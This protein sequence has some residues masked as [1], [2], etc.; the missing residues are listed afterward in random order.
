MKRF[1]SLLFLFFLL[2]S[3]NAQKVS[4]KE[5]ILGAKHFIQRYSDFIGYKVRDVQDLRGSDGQ[6]LGYVAILQPRGFV[7]LT[8]DKRQNPVFGYSTEG[9]FKFSDSYALGIIRR[10]LLADR[11]YAVEKK[12]QQAENQNLWNNL[13]SQKKFSPKDYDYQYGYWLTDVWGGVNC[14]DNNGQIVYVLNYYTPH[15]YSPGCVAV[16]LS[17]VLHYY[18]W[19]PRGTGTHTDYDNE[20]SSTGSYYAKFVATEYDWANM[21]DEYYYKP[22]TDIQRRAAGLLAYHCAIATD[23]DFEYNGST[24]NINRVPN[25]LMS[26]FRMVGHYEDRS[27]SYFVSR[28][29]SNLRNAHPVILSAVADNGDEHAFVCDGY[30]YNVGEEKYYHLNMGWWNAY[31]LNGWYRIF[32]SNFNVGGYTTITAG[33]FDIVPRAYMDKPIYTTDPHKIVL[34]WRMPK[35]VNVTAYKLEESYNNGDWQVISSSITD[36]FYVREV[37]SDGLYKYRVKAQIDGIWYA[38]TYSNYINVPVGKAVYLYFDGDDSFFAYDN[39]FNDLDVDS[40]WTFEAWVEVDDYQDNDWSVIMDRRKV[41]SLYL[42][43]DYDADFAVRFAVRDASDNI[44]A[45]LRS[46]SSDVN[47]S[48]GQWFHVAVSYDGTTA[49]LFINGKQVDES[50]SSAFV[51][52]HSTNALNFAARY[53]GGYSRYL[54]GRLDEIRI[55]DVARYTE[56]F[57]PDRF[58]EFVS[59]A[60]TRLLLHLDNFTGESLFDDSHHIL[61]ISLRS[62]PND[63]SWASSQC[64]IVL[65]SPKNT[66]SCGEQVQMGISAYN[67]SQY[68]W[69]KKDVGDYYDLVNNAIYSGVDSDTLSIDASYLNG[70][71]YFRCIVRNSWMF[72]CSQPAYLKAFGNCTVWDGASW[73]NGLPD[74]NKTAVIAHNY[75][76]DGDIT[77]DN[78]IVRTGD[79]LVVSPGDSFTADFMQNNGTTILQ[80][81]NDNLYSGALLVNDVLNYGDFIVRKFIPASIT[82]GNLYLINSP[83]DSL[84]PYDSLLSSDIT[85]FKNTGSPEQWQM[86]DTPATI[87]NQT[88]YLVQAQSPQIIDFKGNINDGEFLFQL[89]QGWNLLYNPYPCVIDWNSTIGW[90]KYDVQNAIYTIYPTNAG[91]N[92]SVFNGQVS[93]HQQDRYINAMQGFFVYANSDNA[94]LSLNS[95]AKIKT[96]DIQNNTD[97]PTNYL[98]FEFENS[99]GIKDEAIA[100]FTLSGE[101]A[102]KIL[103]LTDEKTYTY[104]VQVGSLLSIAAINQLTPDTVLN[105]GFKTSASGE[106][107]FRVKEFNFSVPVYLKDNLTGDTVRLAEG[108]EYHFTAGTHEPLNRFRLYFGKVLTLK[109]NSSDIKIFVSNGILSVRTEGKAYLKI[110]NMAGQLLYSVPFVNNCTINSL[111]L[112][113]YLVEI[114]SPYSF[115]SKKI[116][117]KP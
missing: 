14:Y 99:D 60:H 13:L 21:L 100:Y 67:A 114:E 103:P 102:Y 23:M 116:F 44:V 4:R 75:Q 40:A 34:H 50:Q 64:P 86:L 5:A 61:G 80:A 81:E 59:D 105:V 41:F 95:N 8:A 39:I 89:K 17:Q 58:A 49:R 53:W 93:L 37:S 92:F 45:S 88:A 79:T 22:S 29:Q 83:L 107:V 56:N 26:Y 68:Q 3:V 12:Q 78:L 20:G 32:N 70:T 66:A 9:D 36:T 82:D 28:L 98:K 52:S 48:L 18:K 111:P 43:N 19:P 71:S 77:A 96:S 72:T 54:T 76:T 104:F 33:V 57:C 62:S 16:S 74:E 87:S 15:H 65:I 108:E 24:S 6:V 42:I 7:L 112:G 1:F 11:F 47:L 85:F 30:R 38:N 25:A 10:F 63:A 91:L 69:Q 115:I 2:V 113:I 46:D 90:Q 97:L 35:N 55:S 110:Y 109:G 84:Y 94:Y 27:W 106:A 51:L 101:N 117:I 31:G 73:S